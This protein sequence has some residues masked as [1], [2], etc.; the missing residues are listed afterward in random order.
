MEVK[1]IKLD[2]KADQRGWLVNLTPPLLETQV[3][4]MFIATIEPGHIRGNHYHKRKTEWLLVLVGRCV[5]KLTD[6][7]TK[8]SRETDLDASEPTLVTVPINQ[9]VKIINH[10]NQPATIMAI[11]NEP[12]D[13]QDP[14]VFTL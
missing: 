6:V 3:K 10:T 8:E 9:E 2:L 13:P 4:H 12:F 5:V 1:R 7:T 11:F 14:D